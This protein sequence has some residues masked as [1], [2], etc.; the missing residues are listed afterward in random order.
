[1]NSDMNRDARPQAGPGAFTSVKYSE[2]SENVVSPS[3]ISLMYV[4]TESAELM[5]QNKTLKRRIV[6]ST[7]SQTPGKYSF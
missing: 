5:H 2:M 4:T 3:C 6:L 7:K 1:M